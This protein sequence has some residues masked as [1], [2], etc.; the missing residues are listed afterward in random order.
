MAT[1]HSIRPGAACLVRRSRATTSQ[2]NVAGAGCYEP[3]RLGAGDYTAQDW[4]LAAVLV[5]E[6]P[7]YIPMVTR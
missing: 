7:E 6:V 2:T 1:G 3:G 5:G 4:L